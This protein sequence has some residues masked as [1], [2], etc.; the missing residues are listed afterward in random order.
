MLWTTLLFLAGLGLVLSGCT[1]LSREECE[2]GDWNKI[3]LQDGRDGRTDDRYLLHAKA[4]SLE[5]SDATRS[6]YTA[7]REKG[8]AIYCTDVRGY[9]EGALGQRYLGV[10]P[11]ALEPDFLKGF[12]LGRRIYQLEARQ[13][14]IA[15]AYRAASTDADKKRL[16]TEDERAKQE[17][18]TLRAQGDALVNASRKRQKKA[19]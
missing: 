10:C 19:N 9:R 2:S 6:A 3:G 16:E 18:A 4:C 15:D 1:T 12:E 14:D 7:G 8:L 5:R 11:K 13:S 17:I